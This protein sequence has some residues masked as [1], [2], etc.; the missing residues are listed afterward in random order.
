MIR[1][2]LWRSLPPVR[3]RACGGTLTNEEQVCP[4]CGVQQKTVSRTTLK[5]PI[6]FPAEQRSRWSIVPVRNRMIVPYPSIREASETDP[7]LEAKTKRALKQASRRRI[8]TVV[9]SACA[10]VIGVI[11]VTHQPARRVGVAE[12]KAHS[13]SGS[14]AARQSAAPPASPPTSSVAAMAAGPA[15]GPLLLMVPPQSADNSNAP[16]LKPQAP[17]PSRTVSA[18]P[19]KP[20]LAP[21]VPAAPTVADATRAARNAL[22]KGELANAHKR[23]QDLAPAR[24]Q[25]AEVR[26]VASQIT[27][28]ERER[29]AALRHARTCEKSRDWKCVASNADS[30]LA[31]D[32]DSIESQTLLQRAHAGLR[33]RQ[34][35]TVMAANRN[36]SPAMSSLT[37]E[38]TTERRDAP[39][40][41]APVAVEP[42]AP[43]QPAF[44]IRRGRGEAH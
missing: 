43:P 25:D 30:A 21:D 31:M 34:A 16:P 37:A 3:C 1:S 44:S 11:A 40:Q 9:S 18:P 14:I 7:E 12:T 15:V 20:A 36:T 22:R 2:T 13:A 5:T 28:R 24:Q 42:E 19:V 29:D 10:L 17:T 26:R 39:L 41:S 23:L 35:A 32:R 4:E 38:L 33:A 27:T 6:I 8:A